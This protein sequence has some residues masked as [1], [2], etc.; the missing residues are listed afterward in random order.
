MDE[1]E[2]RVDLLHGVD[3]PGVDVLDQERVFVLV[4]V[5]EQDGA[6][7]QAD[8]FVLN[9][10]E[11]VQVLGPLVHQLEHL[12][13]RLDDFSVPHAQE[14]FVAH[15]ARGL[16][17]EEFDFDLVFGLDWSEHFFRGRVKLEHCVVVEFFQI[18]VLFV[19]VFLEYLGQAQNPFLFVCLFLVLENDVN[20]SHLDVPARDEVPQAVLVGRFLTE[21]V[22]GD[23]ALLDGVRLFRERLPFLQDEL[24]ASVHDLA[25]LL[26][27]LDPQVARARTLVQLFEVAGEDV[28][29][30]VAVLGGVF[31]ADGV[32]AAQL[33]VVVLLHPALQFD[34][35]LFARLAAVHFAQFEEALVVRLA[36]RTVVFDALQVVHA[37]AL[38]LLLDVAR[39]VQVEA[40]ELV[41]K[42]HAL[43]VAHD[44]ALLLVV[45]G[46]HDAPDG[47]LGP[48][49]HQQHH[50]A[51]LV[52]LR[53][54]A[55]L[56]A[57]EQVRVEVHQLDGLAL[58]HRRLFLAALVV[59][60]QFL[61]HSGPLDVEFD[62]CV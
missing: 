19:F 6:F 46:G 5:G 12:V 36:V 40:V 24:G 49:L 55:L 56:G 59:V 57:H 28:R 3:V 4:L 50:R 7:V 17:F 48:R 1:P 58:Q 51:R 11:Q 52:L 30:D 34:G 45:H 38:L 10:V 14:D 39:L 16:H 21:T 42:Q 13:P 29:T 43:L 20:L 61:L 33:G 23:V 54:H 44:V 37:H 31:E 8:G 62:V 41:D 60:V 35:P 53:R 9:A 15:G 32:P 18:V 26:P 22:L 47:L 2:G 25:H 27:L